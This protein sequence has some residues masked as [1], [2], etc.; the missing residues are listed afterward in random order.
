VDAEFAEEG[1]EGWGFAGP[2]PV[3]TTAA[4]DGQPVLPSFDV[5]EEVGAVLETEDEGCDEIHCAGI[6]EFENFDWFH[7]SG[8]FV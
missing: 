2:E 8:S 3:R 6:V 1:G 4:V 7:F 5:E